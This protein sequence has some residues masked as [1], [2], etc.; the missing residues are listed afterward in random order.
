MRLFFALIFYICSQWQCSVLKQKATM[1]IENQEFQ[2]RIEP[3]VSD[4]KKE[5]FKKVLNDRTRH[6]TV[7]IEDV[8]QSQNAS[9]MS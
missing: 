5:L 1:K 8:F 9:A 4:H 7:V 3:L 6:L 2:D